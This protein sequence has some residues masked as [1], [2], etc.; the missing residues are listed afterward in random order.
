MIEYEA[1]LRLQSID[2][3]LIR[4]NKGLK[5]LPQQQ[6]LKAI[7][8]AKKKIALEAKRALGQR[9]DAELDVEE[10]EKTHARLNEAMQKLR[11]EAQE[12][13]GDFRQA[14]NLE[15]QLSSL[16]K[17][18]EKIEF[19]HGEKVVLLERL[20]KAEK[21]AGQLLVRLDE[22]KSSVAASLEREAADIKAQMRKLTEERKRVVANMSPATY[23]HYE[24]AFER[25]GG[26]AVEKLSGNVPSVCRVKLQP[27]LYNDVRR[28][29]SIT[30]CPYCH[31]MLVT[32][33][34]SE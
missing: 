24:K 16:A 12:G 28:S 2:L 8:A 20:Q 33:D 34:V 26:L 7:E 22:E 1:L 19:T 9:K 10:D 5:V 3:E 6:K 31:R 13:S 14:H 4:L 21:N 15:A 29:G 18:I 25:F 11:H 17:K 23:T 32:E 27:A 30:E